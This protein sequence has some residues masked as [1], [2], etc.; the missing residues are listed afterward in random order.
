MEYISTKEAS[1]KWG[2]SASRIRILANEGR[3]SG[4]KRLGKS[5]LIPAGATKPIELKANHSHIAKEKA[6]AFSF[7]LY[8]FRPDWSSFEE[9]QL[10]RQQQI[11][12]Q[13]ETAVLE[14]RFEEAYALLESIPPDFEDIYTEIGYLWHTGIC[15]IGLNKPDVFSRIFLKFQIVLSKDIPHKKELTIILDALKTYVE[16]IDSSANNNHYNV[17]L[18]EQCLPL[19]CVQIGYSHLTKE[20]VKPNS[21]DI[22]LLELCLRFL[23]TSS[24]VIAMEMM[25][26]YLLGIYYLRQDNIAAKRHAKL[27]VQI[28][29]ENKYYFPLVSFYNYFA[30]VISPILATYPKEFQNHCIKLIS[31]YEKNFTGFL[32]ALSEDS[33]FSRIYQSDYPYIYSIITGDT[34]C[35]IAD[36]LKVSEHTVNRKITNLCNRLG[37]S[38]KKD[39]KDYLRNYL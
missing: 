28:A 17:N 19:L 1:S 4:A 34:N 27:A 22:T 9:D 16:T 36:K 33:V 12:V 15:C 31:Q 23:S 26:C 24:A 11:L 38:N 14:C 18:H 8:H 6:P 35:V 21:T 20:L 5:W 3:I 39:L 25:H 30:P 10:T 7:P 2:I 29:Y 13:A 37:V 32:S